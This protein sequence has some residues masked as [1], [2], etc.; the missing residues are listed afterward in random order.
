LLRAKFP[1]RVGGGVLRRTSAVARRYRSAWCGTK[2][3]AFPYPFF[4]SL[5]QISFSGRLRA[6]LA[7]TPT[8]YLHMLSSSISPVARSGSVSS[9]VGCG[10]RTL[11]HDVPHQRP[12]GRRASARCCERLAMAGAC[13]IPTRLHNARTR[14]EAF[15]HTF[16][17][18]TTRA[19]CCWL[20]P[21]LRAQPTTRPT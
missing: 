8:C 3:S 1:S 7:P 10:D 21:P 20:T 16:Y 19:R 6:L 4:K 2:H 15:K 9:S 17:A 5:F 11:L 18:E 14:L 13:P 12:A